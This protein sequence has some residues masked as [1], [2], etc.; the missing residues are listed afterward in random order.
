MMNALILN[1]SL[2][3]SKCDGS[4]ETSSFQ[5][6]GHFVRVDMAETRPS[7]PENLTESEAGR[8]SEDIGPNVD[9][10]FA[11]FSQSRS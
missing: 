4:K 8:C 6:E 9:S 11:V 2:D 7:N 10:T 3:A 5:A 1:E